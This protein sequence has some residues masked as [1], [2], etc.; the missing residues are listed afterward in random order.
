M[1]CRD[2]GDEATTHL[3]R[4]AL[5]SYY[6]GKTRI[7]DVSCELLG[8]MSSL[9]SVELWETAGVTDA[10]IAAL[11]KLPRLSKIS[12]S[13]APRVSRQGMT[14]FPPRVRVSYDA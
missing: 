13:G 4:L 10:G 7:T 12:V 9:E 5:K 6:A 11:A 1:Y 14:A 8:R 3:D 2:T